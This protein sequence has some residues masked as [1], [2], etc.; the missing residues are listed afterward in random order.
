MVEPLD[1]QRGELAQLEGGAPVPGPALPDDAAA[2]PDR[3][4]RRVPRGQVVCSGNREH[5]QQT[6]AG[7]EQLINRQGATLKLKNFQFVLAPD[8]HVSDPHLL[9]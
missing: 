2:L 8:E 3:A 5:V 6:R 1:E 9:M 4:A 7:T